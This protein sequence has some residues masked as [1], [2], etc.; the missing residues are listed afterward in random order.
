MYSGT[1]LLLGDFLRIIVTDITPSTA[2]LRFRIATTLRLSPFT[3]VAIWRTSHSTT[4]AQFCSLVDVMKH[5]VGN[6]RPPRIIQTCR[7]ADPTRQLY[8]GRRPHKICS[9]SSISAQGRIW[10]NLFGK[11]CGDGPC[12][13]P[14]RDCRHAFGTADDLLCL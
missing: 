4:C 1:S 13:S 14:S 12:Y 11:R 8:W 7:M 10:N 3:L 9:N 5:L 2:A 6:D